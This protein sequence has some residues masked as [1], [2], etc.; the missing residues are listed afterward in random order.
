MSI[1]VLVE[2][3]LTEL[4]TRSVVESAF[5]IERISISS[6]SVIPFDTSAE[7]P[8]MKFTPT[9]CA[10]LSSVCAI[11]TKSSGVLHADPPISAMGVTEILLLTIGIPYSSDIYS[12]VATKS[13]AAS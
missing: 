8:P 7:Y 2:P 10:A 4:H 9:S 13:L 11:D 5:G 6:A 3:T 1:P 12:P